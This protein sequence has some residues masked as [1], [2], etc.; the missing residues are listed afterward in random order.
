MSA[1]PAILGS[2]EA[3]EQVVARAPAEVRAQVAWLPKRLRDL[4]AELINAPVLTDALLDSATDQYTDAIFRIRS[5][6]SQIITSEEALRLVETRLVADVAPIRNLAPWPR[7]AAIR[8]VATIA[9]IFHLSRALIGSKDAQDLQKEFE[10]LDFS[11]DADT[12][13]M[14]R[15]IV[16]FFALLESLKTTS[17]IPGRSAA[18]ARRSD[19]AFHKACELLAQRDPRLRLPWY[20]RDAPGADRAE[21]F[22]V[23]R[24]DLL[25]RERQPASAED[26]EAWNHVK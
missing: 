7:A 19:E 25:Q 12:R 8:S 5:V 22:G 11:S 10:A 24:T 20:F 15:A 26:T 17:A 1:L 14:L 9:A 23:W 16:T 4:F 3:I 18:L 6:A 2:P 21:D 13:L